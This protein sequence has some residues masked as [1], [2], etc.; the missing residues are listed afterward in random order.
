M[1]WL[2]GYCLEYVEGIA[3]S[4]RFDPGFLDAAV[5]ALERR[6]TLTVTQADGE[7]EVLPAPQAVVR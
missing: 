4:E 6:N 1:R 7:Q 3:F 5:A 2:L